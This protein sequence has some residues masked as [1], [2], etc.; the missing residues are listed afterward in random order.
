MR[1]TLDGVQRIKDL[2][3]N[4]AFVT[5]PASEYARLMSLLEDL[6]DAAELAEAKADTDGEKVPHD[7][8]KR[9]VAGEHPVRVWREHR[10]LTA[11]AL[12]ER[13]GL[14]QGYVSQIETGRRDGTLKTMAALG[15]ALDVDLDDLVPF[16]R[17]E[18]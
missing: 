7:L 9:L 13:A 4:D 1:I 18:G 16:E 12:A 10:G 15:R 6:A 3:G 14:S 8:V 5:L 11:A 2:A 17:A